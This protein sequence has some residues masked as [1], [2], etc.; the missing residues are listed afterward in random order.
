MLSLF[1]LLRQGLG[2]YKFMTYKNTKI[3]I[4]LPRQL[5]DI[6]LGTSI[7]YLLRKKFPNAQLDW[8]SH[9]MGSQILEGNP[10]LN[11]VLYYPIYKSNKQKSFIWNVRSFFI[12]VIRSISHVFEVRFRGYDTV[13][14]AMNNPR[15]A[16]LTF[17]SGAKNRVSFSA[18]SIRNLAYNKLVSRDSLDDYYLGHS[19][20]FLLEPLGIPFVKEDVLTIYPTLPT[21]SQNEQAVKAFLNQAAIQVFGKEQDFKFFILSPT[22]RREVRRWPGVSFVDLALR[23]IQEHSLPVIWLWGPNEDGYVFLLHNKLRENLHKKGL[24]PNFSIFPPLLSL[25]ETSVISGMSELWIGNSSGLSHIAVAGGAKTLELHGPTNPM[26]WCH[27]NRKKH[28]YLQRAQGCVLCE[29]NTC[30]LT[31]RECLEDLLV[32]TVFVEVQTMLKQND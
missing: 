13:I 15:S 19:R 32:G 14:D 8:W 29:S 1:C 24:D 16:I 18:Q 23:L 22:H 5:G 26:S 20:L 7:A 10:H 17:M 31:K 4:V 21:S 11:K 6:L 9:P 3:L 25:R 12:F 2:E 30:K 27:P 28:R